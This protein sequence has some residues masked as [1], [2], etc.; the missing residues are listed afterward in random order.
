MFV[1]V[2]CVQWTPSRADHGIGVYGG[3]SDATYCREDS[4]ELWQQLRAVF[5]LQRLYLS[6]AFP[7]FTWCCLVSPW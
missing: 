5:D 2:C 3:S 7:A 1:L 4:P 6:R